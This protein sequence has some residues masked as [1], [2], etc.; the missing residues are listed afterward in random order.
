MANVAGVGSLGDSDRVV[1]LESPELQ[2]LRDSLGVFDEGRFPSFIPHM[3]LPGPA[4]VPA[5]YYIF[6]RL[7][8]WAGDQQWEFP[9]VGDQIIEAAARAL[10]PEPVNIDD[11]P[12]DSDWLKV[13]A[14]AREMKAYPGTWEEAIGAIDIGP[15]GLDPAKYID[16][17]NLDAA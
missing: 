4:S 10:E 17:D 14:K 7:A 15:P 5:N 6:D 9:L 3:S 13:F 11:D 1:L 2:W 12:V 16:V 8:L